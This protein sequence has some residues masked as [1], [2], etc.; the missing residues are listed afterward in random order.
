MNSCGLGGG[1]ARESTV[2]VRLELGG[3]KGGC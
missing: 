1:S 2:G 3:A